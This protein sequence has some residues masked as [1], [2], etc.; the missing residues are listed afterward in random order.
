MQKRGNQ[1]DV[2]T[3]GSAVQ[4]LFI[5]T[6]G[7]RIMKS[8]AFKSGYAE[9]LGVG[10]KN[11]ADDVEIMTGGGATNA[12][13]TFAKLGFK[14]GIFTELGNDEPARMLQEEFETLRITDFSHRNAKK[15]T[16]ISVILSA[17]G[18][19]RSIITYRGASAE[20][21]L[22]HFPLK[23]V[24][25]KW[26]Y[27]TSLHGNIAGLEHV[28]ERA[29]ECGA[30]IAWNPG[31]NELEIG[32]R[33]LKSILKRIN[34][35]IVNREEAMTLVGAKKN[36]TDPLLEALCEHPEYT[37]LTDGQNG[38]WLAALGH[39][40][41]ARANSV[42]IKNTTGAGDA[43]GSG[44]VAGFMKYQDPVH[45]LELAMMNAESV[46]QNVGAKK[47]IL[48]AWPSQAKRETIRVE[49]W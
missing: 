21:T 16:A 12:A 32:F 38:A 39:A 29:E 18:S 7:V 24:A 33:K 15:K 17:P 49:K 37:C 43:F 22:S 1:F 20:I 8:D 28:L 13:A 44:L 26:F 34:I 3:I 4:D 27:I 35:L 30:S 45:A 9:C 2:I 14:T 46:I 36:D 5:L 47:G 10:T 48:T 31:Q 40:W 23:E 41:H 42:P 11:E 6:K 19:D 25:P